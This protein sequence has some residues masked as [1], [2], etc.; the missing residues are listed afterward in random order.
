MLAKF[1][2]RAA[3]ACGWTSHRRRSDAAAILCFHNVVSDR[4]GGQRGDGPLHIGLSRFDQL[5]ER[6]AAV[7]HVVAL[8][9]LTARLRAGR[10]VAGLA[11]LTFDDACEGF[12]ANG[13]PI[14]RRRGLPSAAFVI[15][16]AASRPEPFW[17]DI[18][19][20]TG[21]LN[22]V[23]QAALNDAAGEQ[24]RV[25]AMF[26]PDRL[27]PVPPEMLPA[28]WDRIREALGP[29]LTIGVHTA[30]HPNLMAPTIDPVLELSEARRAVRRELDRDATLASYPFGRH[31]DRVYEAARAVGLSAAMGVGERR[32]RASDNPY[33]MPRVDVPASLSPDTLECRAAGLQLRRAK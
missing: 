10:T 13:L 12:F 19:G 11:A 14:L 27:P 25:L 29:D 4:D 28:T 30:T 16:G 23:R 17:W 5:I 2:Y 20:E 24:D 8:D 21:V 1:A 26:G 7:H 33:G 31:G 6:I 18:L 15:S 9:E 3:I 22:S 32:V